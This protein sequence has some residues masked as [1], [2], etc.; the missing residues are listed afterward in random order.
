MN[1]LQYVEIGRVKIYFPDESISYFYIDQDFV[2]TLSV[3]S[4]TEALKLI[5]VTLRKELN[6]KAYRKIDFDSE[7]DATIISTRSA[8]LI[9]HSWF[10]G[11][12]KNP[13]LPQ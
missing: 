1:T 12:R 11:T 5:K 7:S 8:E 3:E 10:C 4:N 9:K 2:S 13:T 6:A